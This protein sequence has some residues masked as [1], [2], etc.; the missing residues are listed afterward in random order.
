[1]ATR[2]SVIRKS[3]KYFDDGGFVEELSK[4]VEVETE[5]QNPSK[6]HELHRYLEDFI[7][8]LLKNIGFKIEI[9]ANPVLN[10]GPIL[11]GERIEDPNL[12]TMLSYGHGDVTPPQED[13]WNEGLTPYKIVVK[14]GRIY[15]R[16]TA[17]N[18]CQHLINIRALACLIEERGSLGFNVKFVI[19]TSEEIGSIG[20][21]E[22]FLEHKERLKSDLM[23]ASDGPRVDK[24]VP[25]LFMGSRGGLCFKI[26]VNLR[27]GQNHSGNWGGLL[28]DPAIYLAHAITCIVDSRGQLK[29]PEWRPRSLTP[30]IRLALKNIPAPMGGVEISS[31]WGEVGLTPAERAFGW[32]SFAV[33]AI[34]SG[35]P[36]AQVNAIAGKASAICQLR[37][38][39]GTE[40]DEILPSLR[41]ELD[42]NDLAMVAINKVN[43]NFLNATR[44]D[45]DNVWVKFCTNS[46]AKTSGKNP[47]ILPNL[48]GSLPND[49]FVDILN[50]TTVWI[51]H[52][53]AGCSQHAPNEHI[54]MATSRDSLR[55]MAGL[56]WDIAEYKFNFHMSRFQT[57]DY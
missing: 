16:G 46:L 42:N 39:V 36:K 5:S 7:S 20:L 34:D 13:E 21:R 14:G 31:E 12:V 45:L 17:D 22:F 35:D 37:F 47:H 57:T 50:V 23:I 53:Y 8:P 49:V 52:S 2:E 48:A 15:G 33:L 38:V 55:N 27:E 32:N 3:E 9:F 24:D 1:M 19:E 4:L 30:K 41:R 51:P 56:F 29:I 18:K 28:A 40:L 26:D 25:T 11:I 44:E 54:L 6:R 10:G 43:N